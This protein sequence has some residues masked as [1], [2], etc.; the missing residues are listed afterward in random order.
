MKDLVAFIFIFKMQLIKH[1][2]ATEVWA[3]LP[4]N[5]ITVFHGICAGII[6]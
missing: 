5:T 4:K 6:L 2:T 1:I 3:I